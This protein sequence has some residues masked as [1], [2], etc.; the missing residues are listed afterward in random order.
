[1]K[2]SFSKTLALSLIAFSLVA[3]PAFCLK[4]SEVVTNCKAVSKYWSFKKGESFHCGRK[5]ALFKIKGQTYEVSSL[6]VVGLENSKTYK[7][8]GDLVKKLDLSEKNSKTMT[9]YKAFPDVKTEEFHVN[10][11][12]PKATILLSLRPVQSRQP[13]KS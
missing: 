4:L 8:F 7:N 6:R 1:M 11:E 9:P 10:L 13:V 2:H 12:D 3:Q 5:A